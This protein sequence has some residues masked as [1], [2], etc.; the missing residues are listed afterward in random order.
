MD[1]QTDQN[2]DQVL[3]LKKLFKAPDEENLM[4]D[5]TNPYSLRNWWNSIQALDIDSYKERAK[6]YYR[7]L[8]FLPGSYKLWYNFLHESTENCARY[9]VTNKRYEFINKLFEKSLIYMNKMPRIWLEYAKF[10]EK[11]QMISRTRQIYERA[12]S[13]LPI[14]Q[15]DLVWNPYVAWIESLES[16]DLIKA[17]YRRYLKYAP[18]FTDK[19]INILLDYKEIQEA[20]EMYLKILEE[21]NYELW[22]QL[23]E[24]ISKNPTKLN[25]PN[26][27]E[28]IRHGIRKYTD[29]VGKLW[30]C[31][32]DYNTRLGNF[33]KAREIFEE[34]I[35][36]VTTARDFGIVYNA[37]LNFEETI[38][39]K[40]AEYT[41]YDTQY[42]EQID[43]LIDSTLNAI[44]ER[45]D[46]EQLSSIDKQMMTEQD[47]EN[48]KYHK[49]ESLIERRE[50]LLS[51]AVLRQNPSNVHEWLQRIALCEN[52]DELKLQTYLEAIFQ[53]NPLEAYG[54][55]SKIWINFARFYEDH[56]DLKNANEIY[57]RAIK[58]TFRNMDELATIYCSWAE[59]H[60][61]H[62]NYESALLILHNA[63]N[64]KREKGQH[65]KER[66]N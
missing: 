46:D 4:D 62:K 45:K 29:E 19:Y 37:Y 31:L 42:E 58:V 57:K 41:E 24:I 38:I 54:K 5:I 7:A 63:C 53:I 1:S 10:M 39:E 64:S 66:D 40:D 30:I 36:S 48:Y 47:E 61:R 26:A 15:H 11:Q 44:D 32:A 65:K 14:T 3:D 51:N 34:A 56:S 2:S 27:E 23:C 60:F 59:M 18:Q 17:V 28:I 43:D 22:M 16:I 49:L 33:E 25:L 6:L 13:S 52:D 12:L 8:Y 50:F 55:A 21:D 9:P 35:A 20:V